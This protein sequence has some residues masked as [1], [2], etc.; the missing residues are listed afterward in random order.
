MGYEMAK[1]WSSSVLIAAV[2]VVVIESSQVK[3]KSIHGIQRGTRVIAYYSFPLRSTITM[4]FRGV[5]MLFLKILPFTLF[6]TKVCLCGLHSDP[7]CG[8]DPKW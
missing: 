5:S 7:S 8:R 2:V 1:C 4:S 3:V 6:H